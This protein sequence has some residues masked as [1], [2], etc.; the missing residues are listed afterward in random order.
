MADRSSSD[1]SMP[2]SPGRVERQAEASTTEARQ[3]TTPRR[4]RY[5]LGFGIPIVVIGFLIVYLMS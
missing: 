1:T 2:P 4:L 3:G 5:M